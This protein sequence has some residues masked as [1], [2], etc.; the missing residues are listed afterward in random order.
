M[1]EKKRR[2]GKKKTKKKK[3]KENRRQNEKKFR[4]I[5]M[6]FLDAPHTAQIDI[7]TQRTNNVREVR[8]LN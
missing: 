3:C 5:I 2:K 1:N 7:G 4:K 8:F 6:R